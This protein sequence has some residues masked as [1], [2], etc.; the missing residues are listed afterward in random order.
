MVIT[1]KI[2]TFNDLTTMKIDSLNNF[3]I[4]SLDTSNLKTI[5][6]LDSDYSII[7]NNNYDTDSVSPSYRLEYDNVVIDT[8][9]NYYVATQTRNTEGTYFK[10]VTLTRTDYGP[11][12]IL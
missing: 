1:F 10:T 6:K 11:I 4:L 7:F 3:I 9:D 8:S 12:M 5:T 2:D